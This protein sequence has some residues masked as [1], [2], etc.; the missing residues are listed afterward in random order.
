MEVSV[1]QQKALALASAR[2]RL[3]QS[4][5]PAPEQGNMYTQGAEDIQY[6]P[7]G[8]PLNTSSYG[9]APTGGTDVAR[10]ALTTVVSVPLNMATGAAKIPA[11]IVQYY[12]KHFGGDYVSPN[13]LSNLVTG[14]K[15]PRQPQGIGDN[16]VNAINQIEAG[17]QAQSGNIGKRILQGSSIVGEAAPYMMS[18]LKVGAPTFLEGMA[19]KAAPKVAEI[20]AKGGKYV[21]ETIGMLPSFVQK[22]LP[23][24]ELVGNVAKNTAIGGATAYTSPEEVGLSPEEYNKAKSNKANLGMAIGGGLPIVG[25]TLSALNTSTGLNLG[26]KLAETPSQDF[27]ENKAST[28]FKEARDSGVQLDPKQF[29]GTMGQI[30]KDLRNEG[31]DPRLYPK[32]GVAI[33]ELKNI[34]TTKDFNELNTLRKFIMGAQKSVDPEERRLATMLKADFDHYIANIPDSAVIGGSKEGL[35]AWKEARDTYTKLSK[36]DIFTEMLEKAKLEKHKLTQSGT[37]NALFKELRKLAENPK[38]MRLFTQAEQQAIIEAGKGGNVQNLMRFMSRFTPTGPVSGMFAG[39]AILAHPA[40]ALPFEAM[41]ILSKAGA[42]KIRKDDVTKLA[43]MMRSG[44]M[45]E[46]V[47][48]PKFTQNQRDMAKL[49]LLQGTERGMNNE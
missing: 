6:S 29:S 17:S 42:T 40:I 46:M 3:A 8:V 7:E 14:N 20:A 21:D 27:L 15:A 2:L 9:S 32:I 44:K 28:L 41:S 4:A 34:K 43:A 23:S 48:N 35:T 18:P 25:K 12:D 30:A 5:A 31:Y 45:P 49:L 16:M 13:N 33:D 47:S 36:A 11:S 22:V 37:E 24:A 10:K 38:R 39:G 26:R 1:E 19:L